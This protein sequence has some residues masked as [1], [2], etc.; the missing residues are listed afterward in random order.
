MSYPPTNLKINSSGCTKTLPFDGFDAKTKQTSKQKTLLSR[1]FFLK[2]RLCYLVRGRKMRICGP[3][4]LKVSLYMQNV[5]RFCPVYN[6]LFL[7]GSNLQS[8]R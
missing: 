3:K 1:I 7:P 5:T 6:T 8:T 4:V 2:M